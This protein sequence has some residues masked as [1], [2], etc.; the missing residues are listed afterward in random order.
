[1]KFSRKDNQER[2]SK[3]CRPAPASPGST[4]PQLPP[5]P[6]P[7]SPRSEDED[8]EDYEIDNIQIDPTG[9]PA[10]EQ[11]VHAE[12]RQQPQLAQ[13]LFSPAE[14]LPQP[15][16]S[17]DEDAILVENV[18]YDPTSEHGMI[19]QVARQLNI[20]TETPDE[21]PTVHEQERQKPHLAQNMFS[22]A[23]HLEIVDES[24]SPT[25]PGPPPLHQPPSPEQPS[26]SSLEEEVIDVETVEEQPTLFV[27]KDVLPS[28]YSQIHITTIY[29]VNSNQMKSN[30]KVLTDRVHEAARLLWKAVG[31]ADCARARPVRLPIKAQ[32]WETIDTRRFY[33]PMTP[34]ARSQNVQVLQSKVEEFFPL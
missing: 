34:K 22:P 12:E 4:P 15:P 20:S 6:V 25:F 5:S 13:E 24:S 9:N 1:M 33:D 3:K 32:M 14:H 21:R 27:N 17:L 7:P 29:T 30:Q 10:E 28:I 2:H 31:N 19:R 23:E 18:V 11:T 8:T 16:Q 26:R